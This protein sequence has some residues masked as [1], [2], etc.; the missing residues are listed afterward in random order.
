[1]PIHQCLYIL[2]AHI[3]ILGNA[4][5]IAGAVVAVIVILAIAG[6]ITGAVIFFV[7]RSRS[8]S[9]IARRYA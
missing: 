1:M 6:G 2:C 4:G 8:P 9:Y 7:V 3:L 5:A